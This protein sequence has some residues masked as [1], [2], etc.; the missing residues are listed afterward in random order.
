MH[1]VYACT[2]NPFPHIHITHTTHP[3]TPMHAVSDDMTL[4]PESQSR[5]FL[6]FLTRANRYPT[7]HLGGGD[8]PHTTRKVVL[9]E[10]CTK[11]RY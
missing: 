11:N 9:V 10:V 8:S 6:M 4:F 1:T 2:I 3:H 5:Q 7:L